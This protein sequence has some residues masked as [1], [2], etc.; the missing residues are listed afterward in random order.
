MPG[1]CHRLAIDS[2]GKYVTHR[3]RKVG[4]VKR[5]TINE[6]VVM[7]KNT[8]F[9]PKVKYKTLFENPQPNGKCALISLI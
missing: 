3:N 5:V 7:L 4:E 8:R 2:N 6:E 1:V 9:I